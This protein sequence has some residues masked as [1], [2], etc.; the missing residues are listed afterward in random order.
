MTTTTATT[1][2][3]EKPPIWKVA[4]TEVFV[5]E[6]SD[7]NEFANNWEIAM[8][9]TFLENVTVNSKVEKIDFSLSKESC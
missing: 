1:T 9:F 4:E 3:T 2:T 6:F 8:V 5:D 7:D